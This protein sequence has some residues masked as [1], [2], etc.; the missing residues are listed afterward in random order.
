MGVRLSGWTGKAI[1]DEPALSVSTGVAKGYKL[2]I[3]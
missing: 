2:R 1:F 3:G